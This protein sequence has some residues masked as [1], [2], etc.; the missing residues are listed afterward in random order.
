MQGLQV[1]NR[2]N[3]ANQRWKILYHD[4]REKRRTKGMNTDFGLYI[5]RPFYIRS[6]LPFQRVVECHGASNVKLARWRKNTKAQQWYFDE[7]TKTIKNNNW[8]PRSLDIQSN[9]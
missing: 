2:H 7:K 3:G 5:N 6:R 8:T 9:G 4:E 1:H